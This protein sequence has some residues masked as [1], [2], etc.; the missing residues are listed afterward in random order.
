MYAR[1]GERD[2]T[3]SVFEGVVEQISPR[4]RGIRTGVDGFSHECREADEKPC[5]CLRV[6]FKMGID[7]SCVFGDG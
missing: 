6:V 4:I 5:G 3:R 2:W 1:L 7:A